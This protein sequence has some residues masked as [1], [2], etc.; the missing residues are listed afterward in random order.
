MAGAVIVRS[1]GISDI[2]L[3]R[4]LI[5]GMGMQV[6]KSN[7][8]LSSVLWLDD[9]MTFAVEDIAALK[10]FAAIGHCAVTAIYCKRGNSKELTCGPAFAPNESGADHKW[11]ALPDGSEVECFPVIAG[12]GAMM[13]SRDDFVKSCELSQRCFG[14]TKTAADAM[15]AVCFS[16]PMANDDGSY[17]WVSE[18]RAYSSLLWSVLP[19]GLFAVPVAVGHV[20]EVALVPDADAVWL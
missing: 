20:S 1:T 15:P 5:A 11:L 6:L 3:H 2:A 13:L 8:Q 19:G 16:G 14:K 18:D 10:Y 7:E 17:E 9:D 4:N 12:M